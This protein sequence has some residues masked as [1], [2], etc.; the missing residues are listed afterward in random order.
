LVAAAFVVLFVDFALSSKQKALL[1]Y[2]TVLGLAIPFVIVLQDIV[3][4]AAGTPQGTT[5]NGMLA[6]D[7]FSRF[8][9]ILVL[10]VGIVIAFMSIPALKDEGLDEAGY[11]SLILLSTVGM[12]LMVQGLDLI[13][14][15][16]GLETLSIAVYVLAGYRKR[17][18]LS[19]ESGLK[20]FLLGAFAAAFLL[21]GIALLY[22]ATG[23][24]NVGVIARYIEAQGLVEDP[25]VLIGMVL[26]LVGMGFKLALVPFHSWTPDVYEGAPTAVTAFMAVGVKAAAIGAFVRIFGGALFP[27]EV[28]WKDLFW[29][30]AV[31]TMTLG[32]IV[33]LSQ[34]NIKRMLAYSSIA[35]AGYMMIG[36]VAGGEAGWSA[37]LFYMVAYAFMNLGA[38]AIVLFYGQK[39]E[40]HVEIADYAGLGFRYPVLGVAMAIFVFSL[41]GFPPL[42][43]FVGKFYIFSAAI[44]SG[45]I[46]LTIIGVLNSL[47]SVFYYFRVTIVM[48]MKEPVVD[49]SLKYGLPIVVVLLVTLAGTIHMGLLP[50]VYLEQAIESVQ[51]LNF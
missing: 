5:F 47:I 35:H 12:L 22:G 36:I 40:A 19:A 6:I 13:V 7:G 29:F 9:S 28:E 18:K 10:G 4:G 27:L 48:Y 38:F 16:L 21:Y 37:V 51:W 23:S 17:S 43:G 25:L 46:W 44:K 8:F 39:E 11:Y 1:G 15:F 32:N 45:Y 3:G 24:T 50:T 30:L 2:L 41:A 26:V 49:V 33:A 14:I 42:A 34:T 31:I 20:Y